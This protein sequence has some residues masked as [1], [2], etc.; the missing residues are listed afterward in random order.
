MDAIIIDLRDRLAQSRPAPQPQDRGAFVRATRNAL[1]LTTEEFAVVLGEQIGWEVWPGHIKAWES[2]SA[3]VIKE[4]A[5]AC[6]R[7]AVNMRPAAASPGGDLGGSLVVP[8][9]TDGRITWVTINRRTFLSRGGTAALAAIAAAALPPAPGGASVNLLSSAPTA[10]GRT[11]VEHL[12]ALR[13]VLIDADN[14]LGSAAVV[15]VTESQVA[16]IRH[17]LDGQDGGDRRALLT[18]QAQFAE[19][20]GWL[21]QD[22]CDFEQAQYW[23]DRSLEWAHM[24]GEQDLATYILLRK[25][26]LA[27]DMGQAADAADLAEAAAR[28]AVPR[29]RIGATAPCFGAHGYALAGQHSAAERAIDRALNL[30]ADA[31]DGSSWAIWLDPS[32][33]KVQHARCLSALGQ[34][35]RAAAVFGDAIGDIGGSY[36]RDCGVYLGRQALAYARACE[37]EQAVA[38]GMR[39][40]DVAGNAQSGRVTAELGNVRIALAR[41]QRLPDVARFHE[42]LADVIPA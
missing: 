20:A 33:I 6:H 15:P 21:R 3:R 31:D 42:A 18:L 5:E 36:R 38:A 19:F 24:A 10:D 32:Y 37:P 4:V 27:G 25:S 7:L 13:R 8:C 16:V 35:G 26:Q 12:A 28:M 2:G 29:S 39:A 1:G 23:L 22:G 41:W 9:W 17:L 40:L 11:P 34:H 14:Q 30:E